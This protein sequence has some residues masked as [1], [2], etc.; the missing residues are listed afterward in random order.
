DVE[1]NKREFRIF[2][3]VI[4]TWQWAKTQKSINHH[5]RIDFLEE[6]ENAVGEE[7]WNSICG[8]PL[9]I[10]IRFAENKFM[11]SS[12]IVEH[13]LV[14]QLV[15]KDRQEM[16]CL[17]EFQ[18]IT[19]LNCAPFPESEEVIETKVH[20]GLWKKLKVKRKSPCHRELKGALED[21]S[22]WSIEEKVRFTYL[23]ILATVIIGEDDKKELSFELA[24]MVFDLPKFEKYPWGREAFKRLIESVKRIDLNAKSYTIDGFVQ[25]LQVWAYIVVP[26]LGAKFGRPTKV[27]GPPILKFK[28]L[29]G[30][31]NIDIHVVSVADEEYKNITSVVI[32]QTTPVVW[33]SKIA[34]KKINTLLQVVCKEGGL[35][36]VTWVEAVEHGSNII[37]TE[38]NVAED[39]GGNNEEG[40]KGSDG[41]DSGMKKMKADSSTILSSIEYAEAP[42][43]R[44]EFEKQAKKFETL[45]A[46][47]EDIGKQLQG[48]DIMR[49]KFELLEQEVTLLRE[50]LKTN[51]CIKVPHLKDEDISTDDFF[52]DIN[53]VRD[54][55]VES[56]EESTVDGRI[57]MMNIRKAQPQEAP[58]VKIIEPT[59]S[60]AEKFTKKK[61]GQT[62]KIMEV[63][64]T[65]IV[66]DKST[67]LTMLEPALQTP[68]QSTLPIL[69]NNKQVDKPNVVMGRGYDPFAPVDVQKV[70]SLDDWLHLD[71]DYPIGSQNN[72]VEFFR[73]L[74]TPQEWLTGEHI[75]SATNLLRLRFI[76][77]QEAFRTGRIAFTDTYFTTGWAKG[78]DEFLQAHDVPIFPNGTHDYCSGKLPAFAETRKKWRTEVDNIYGVLYVNDNH[79][80]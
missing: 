30:R 73:V 20:K 16:W 52:A 53:G 77:N 33:T 54:K 15:C 62:L 60:I 66:R 13:L 39:V 14:N 74:R 26:S 24:H 2:V 37:Q 67:R 47:V 21:V 22:E 44:L 19:N 79:W 68:F 3:E 36:D 17:L 75:N 32:N 50:K 51:E 56:V 69:G 38:K 5:C 18:K 34:D 76:K 49:L 23:C 40:K 6:V 31:N 8:S 25:T 61:I 55:M 46:K 71:E 78:Y 29:K 7:V 64:Q 72:G 12:K 11:W 48:F 65:R 9:G 1:S 27:D 42:Q 58:P 45:E 57:P 4:F 80:I 28:G 63:D 41:T 43:M 10:V 59:A 70:K 35:G